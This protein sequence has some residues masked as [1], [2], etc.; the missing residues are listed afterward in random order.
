MVVWIFYVLIRTMMV[1][2]VAAAHLFEFFTVWNWIA[3][4]LAGPWL[5]RH[6]DL[7]FTSLVTWILG[8]YVFW[9]HPRF[10]HIRWLPRIERFRDRLL[11]D[12][13]G[14]VLP[15][16]VAVLVYA[17]GRGVTPSPRAFCGSLLLLGV[18]I[19]TVGDLTR[20]YR[21]PIERLAW[22]FAL[23]GLGYVSLVPWG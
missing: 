21:L 22:M 12:A 23:L 7:V 9:I 10:L 15:M 1:P 13:V 17:G 18:Y 14:H 20:V 16:I 5:H 2:P 11:V 6:V 8:A 19:W 3:V 4:I